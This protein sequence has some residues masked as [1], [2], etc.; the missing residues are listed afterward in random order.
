MPPATCST[1]CSTKAARFT[2]TVLAP[3]NRVGDEVGCSYDKASGDVT[4]PPGFKQAYAQFVDGGWAGLVAPV[5]FGGQGLPHAIGVP[6][7]EM[8]DAANLAWGNFP[9]LSHGAI[10]ALLQHGEAW[11]QEA[12]L[13]PL[14]RRPLDR[15]DVPDRTALRHRPRPA[16]DQGRTAAPTAATRSPAP[17][18]SSPPASTTSPTTSCTWCWRGCPTHRPAARAS[19]CSSCRSSTRR[20]RRQRRRAQ[21]RALRR[22][23]AQDG[24]PRLG[25]LRD[26]LRRRAGL[27]DRRAAQGPGWRCSR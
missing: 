19:R 22:D 1:R 24:H 14:D 9:L 13:K 15:H 18:S 17:R 3:L 16:Q 21:R 6:L 11:Q 12:F 23:R 5:E 20:P 27:A 10:E 4:T 25:H 8:I 26:E 2:E 7:K